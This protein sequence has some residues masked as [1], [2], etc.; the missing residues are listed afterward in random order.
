MKEK[1][2]ALGGHYDPN[3]ERVYF[4]NKTIAAMI[5]EYDNIANDGLYFMRLFYDLPAKDFYYANYSP[6]SGEY[7]EKAIKA[8]K[9]ALK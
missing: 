2:I 9:E 8:I 4:D 6:E 3:T 1:L 5:G 7:A